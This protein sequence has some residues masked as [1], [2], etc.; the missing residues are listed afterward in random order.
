MIEILAWFFEFT[1]HILNSWIIWSR[2]HTHINSEPHYSTYS[3]YSKM[4]FNM[5][6]CKRR[7]LKKTVTAFTPRNMPT[8]KNLGR[9]LLYRRNG[10]LPKEQKMLAK[11]ASHQKEAESDPWMQPFWTVIVN[12]NCP[13]LLAERPSVVSLFF[14]HSSEVSEN[15]DHTRFFFWLMKTLWF[16]GRKRKKAINLPGFLPES[17]KKKL[18]GDFVS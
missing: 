14:N 8:Q 15:W 18:E 7:N 1:W 2:R 3:T 11:R 5:S 16:F 6:R 9:S 13:L 4:L 17:K 10:D 12:D